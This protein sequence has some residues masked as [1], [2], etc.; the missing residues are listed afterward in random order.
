MP[1]RWLKSSAAIALDATGAH[2]LFS[3]VVGDAGQPLVLG[4]HRVVEDFE[5]SARSS[6][7]PMLISTRMLEAHLDWVGSRYRFA[8]LDEIG[9]ALES[10]PRGGKPLAAVTFD[11]GYGDFHRHA[12]PLLKRKGIPSAVFVVSGMI[13]ST[14]AFPHDRLYR[15]MS[16]QRGAGEAGSHPLLR[17][18]SD[19]CGFNGTLQPMLLDPMRA[20]RAFLER[21]TQ[22]ILLEM[23]EALER[24]FPLTE[25]EMIDFTPLTRSMILELAREG[26]TIGSHTRTHTL[27]TSETPATVHEEVAGSRAD[28]ERL[29]GSRVDHFAYPDGRFNRGVADALR[30]SGYRYGYTTCS[31]RDAAHP[32]LTIQRRVLWENSCLDAR[33][34]FSPS[35]MSCHSRSVFDFISRCRMDHR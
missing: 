2:R 24:E 13:D 9:A 17:S 5:S 1:A 33:G 34:R 28:L 21:L 19:R 16:L 7:A 11:D 26:V 18:Y 6:I 30:A 22:A 27:L 32:L 23:L 15:L 8:T 20:T 4:Y 12:F 35:V 10:G 31:H 14:T 29:I 3:A 25:R